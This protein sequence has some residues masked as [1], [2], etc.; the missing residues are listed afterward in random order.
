MYRRLAALLI[1]P[2][3]ANKRLEQAS[4]ETGGLAPVA[5]AAGRSA[6]GH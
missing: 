2:T 6:A 3:E 1:T 5:V 4:R